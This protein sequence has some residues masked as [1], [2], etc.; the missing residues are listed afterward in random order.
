MYFKEIKEFWDEGR[1]CGC[2]GM[3]KMK[4]Y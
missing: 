3:D 2:V 4:S 1:I